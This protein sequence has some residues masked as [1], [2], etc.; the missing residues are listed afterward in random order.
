[1]PVY[2][3]PATTTMVASTLNQGLGFCPISVEAGAACV[4]RAVARLIA[5]MLDMQD[6]W[7]KRGSA[8][9]L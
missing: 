2:M 1:M 3:M 9:D 4:A 8:L 6:P 7:V 5:S